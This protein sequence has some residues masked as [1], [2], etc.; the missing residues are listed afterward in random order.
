MRVV[1]G[2]WSS[3]GAGRPAAGE[4]KRQKGNM[5]GNVPN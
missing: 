3:Q 4:S 1:V 2:S 5:Y